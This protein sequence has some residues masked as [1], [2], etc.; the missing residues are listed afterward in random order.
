MLREWI[1][2]NT[3]SD[4]TTIIVNENISILPPRT[5]D[6]MTNLQEVVL[7]KNL[8]KIGILSFAWCKG[9]REIVIPDGVVLIYQ[10]ALRGFVNFLK[11]NITYE[12]V[13]IGK[14]AI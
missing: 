10:L 5:F 14:K 11:V 7:P 3:K 9:L 8:K 1:K 2:E 6:G 4:G 13:G 12:I